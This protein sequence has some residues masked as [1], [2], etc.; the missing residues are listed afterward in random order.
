[1]LRDVEQQFSPEL[2][3]RIDEIAVF[4]PLS[5]DQVAVIARHYV[6]ALVARLADEGKVISVTDAAVRWLAR[7]GYSVRFGARHLKRQI[8]RRLKRPLTAL[9]REGRQFSVDMHDG[10]LVIVPERAGAPMQGLLPA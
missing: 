5:E 9:W 7:D 1:M 3:N 10:A 2:L 6:D 8:D 4:T